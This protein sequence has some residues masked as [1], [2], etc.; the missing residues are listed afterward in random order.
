MIPYI[1]TESSPQNC[2]YLFVLRDLFHL[3]VTEYYPDL[4][5]RMHINVHGPATVTFLLSNTR[6]GLGQTGLIGEIVVRALMGVVTQ[7][8][9]E[10]KSEFTQP[11]QSEGHLL[12]LLLE[13]A[14]W[15]IT[16]AMNKTLV[17]QKK[18]EL[19]S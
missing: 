19:P 8:W 5:I 3:R 14:N 13:M 9:T 16:C 17:W 4:R 2:R 15:F 7:R 18:D 11:Y 12:E 6:D 10:S 1:G